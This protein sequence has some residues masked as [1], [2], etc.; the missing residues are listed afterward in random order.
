VNFALWLESLL[1]KLATNNFFGNL[2]YFQVIEYNPVFRCPGFYWALEIKIG[3][4]WYFQSIL[5]KKY[6]PE[7]QRNKLF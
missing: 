3:E 6:F 5:K 4:I 2:L 1:T 7:N